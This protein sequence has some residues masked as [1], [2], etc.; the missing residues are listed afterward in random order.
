MILATHVI[1]N[2]SWFQLGAV[3]WMQKRSAGGFLT[4]P[5]V[6]VLHRVPHWMRQWSGQMAC[7]G[8]KPRVPLEGQHEVLDVDWSVG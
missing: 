7:R 2:K 8:W 6:I 1:N 5:L 3:S 4:S